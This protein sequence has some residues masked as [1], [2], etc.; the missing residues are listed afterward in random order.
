M[1]AWHNFSHGQLLQEQTKNNI[2]EKFRD[3]Q[4]TGV[5]GCR[6]FGRA[7]K[8]WCL[9]KLLDSQLTGVPGCRPD[10]CHLFYTTTI[11]HSTNIRCLWMQTTWE[12][13]R[14]STQE[15][16]SHER[17]WKL[18]SGFF[19]HFFWNFFFGSVASEKGHFLCV[20]GAFVKCNNTVAHSFLSKK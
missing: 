15:D 5:S 19:D 1:V 4:L 11:L 17:E 6:A 7:R 2:S 18:Q 13:F 14:R 3:S 12:E 8:N 16:S 20:S 9:R 10:I